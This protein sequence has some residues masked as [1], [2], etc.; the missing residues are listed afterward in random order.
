MLSFFGVVG[1]HACDCRW[2]AFMK[3]GCPYIDNW[4]KGKGEERAGRE[5]LKRYKYGL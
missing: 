4:I 1:L 2:S 3:Q 5:W